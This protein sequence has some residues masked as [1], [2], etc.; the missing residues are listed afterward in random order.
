MILETQRRAFP[1]RGGLSR[2]R[3]QALVMWQILLFPRRPFLKS[4]IQTFS[5]KLINHKKFVEVHEKA[6]IAARTFPVS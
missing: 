1:A 5:C 2:V 3:E 4:T 6:F